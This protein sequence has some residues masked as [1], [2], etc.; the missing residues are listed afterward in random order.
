MHAATIGPAP[1]R[2]ALPDDLHDDLHASPV[3]RM[4][5]SPLAAIVLLGL[6]VLLASALWRGQRPGAT[7][8]LQARPLVDDAAREMHAR[9]QAAFPEGWVMVKVAMSALVSVPLRERTRL[10]HRQVDFVLCDRS[11]RVL[12]VV[13]MQPDEELDAFQV[14]ESAATLLASAGYPVLAWREPPT[15]EALAAA[16]APLRQAGAV[17]LRTDAYAP[18]PS[19]H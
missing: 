19:G 13:L 17:P 1:R 15:P 8:R 3:H 18:G 14:G 9:L 5:L 4:F 16:L 6:A 7:L 10:R 12:G 11:L 2:Q